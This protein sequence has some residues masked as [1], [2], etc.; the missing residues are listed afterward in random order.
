MFSR[1]RHSASG[2]RVASADA[3]GKRAKIVHRASGHL[4]QVRHRTAMRTR[5]VE[6]RCTTGRRARTRAHA[7]WPSARRR[8]RG[9]RTRSSDAQRGFFRRRRPRIRIERRTRSRARNHACIL[10]WQGCWRRSLSRRRSPACWHFRRRESSHAHDRAVHMW[11][12]SPRSSANDSSSRRSSAL[13]WRASGVSAG[14]DNK[15]RS[16][17]AATTFA[18]SCAAV[19]PA[20][21]TV[22]DRRA[23]PLRRFWRLQK[24]ARH[25]RRGRARR[26]R[27]ARRRSSRPPRR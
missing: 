20:R 23:D 1:S 2:R 14:A 26:R 16:T 8:H 13:R 27:A 3:S 24:S 22:P 19:R 4:S 25:G 21:S 12:V 18:R 9:V 5:V 11:T 17:S 10:H 6:R 15:P 7:R